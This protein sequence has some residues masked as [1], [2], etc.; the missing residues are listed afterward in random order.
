MEVSNSYNYQG[1]EALTGLYLSMGETPAAWR[2]TYL[3]KEILW[4]LGGLSRARFA[5]NDEDLMISNSSEEIR[6]EREHR[7][8]SADGLDGLLLLGLGRRGWS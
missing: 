6:P 8:A 4:D 3:L 7:K 1:K 5:L 2:V